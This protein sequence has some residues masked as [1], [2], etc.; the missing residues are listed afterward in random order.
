M[1]AK[2]SLGQNFLKSEGII[3]NIVRAGNLSK[4][5]VVLEV[6]PGHGELT[7]EILTTSNHV[8][9]IEKDDYLASKLQSLFKREISSGKLK[10]INGDALELTPDMLSLKDGEFKV[11]ANIPYYITGHLIRLYLGAK[12]K[13]NKMVLLVQKEVAERIIDDK[14]SLLSLSVKAYGEPNYVM[15]VESEHFSPKP[16]VDSAVISIN[17]ISRSFFK[18]VNFSEE[19]FF[20]LIKA[21]FAHKRKFLMNNLERGGVS[22]TEVKK[23]F[24]EL[25]IS[26]KTRA[27]D[28]SLG[29]WKNILIRVRG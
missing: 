6:G 27:E 28:I 13:P 19:D 2:K 14:E 26:L 7:R 10:V 21:G 3:K 1:R 24:D 18:D 23:I 9:A 25:G 20:T 16:K 12:S 17:N 29:D 22:K 15:T 11:I 5:D 8:I 4:E